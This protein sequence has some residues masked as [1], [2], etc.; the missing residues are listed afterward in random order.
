[1]ETT[2]IL[3]AKEGDQS[4]FE[5]LVKMYDRRVYRTAYSFL[6][7]ME[8]AQDISQEVFLKLHRGLSGYDEGRPFF[9]YL[10][11]IT[12]NLCFTRMKS[13]SWR[14]EPLPEKEEPSAEV[15]PEETVVRKEEAA[16][17]RR[18]VEALPEKLREVIELKHFQDCSYREM[19]EILNIPEGTVMSRLYNARKALRE[20]LLKE[21]M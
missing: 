20:E 8:E 9:P 3:Q 4:A 16:G 2:L 14:T 17:V 15:G 11:Q 19:A 18:A 12:K 5:G 10:Y 21:E 6:K 7:D 13:R 1:M